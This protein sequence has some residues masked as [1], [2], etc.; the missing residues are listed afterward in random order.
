MA[1]N[2]IEKIN[3]YLISWSNHTKQGVKY[4]IPFLGMR[5]PLLKDGYVRVYF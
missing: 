5:K 1:L 3:N 4:I 2:K